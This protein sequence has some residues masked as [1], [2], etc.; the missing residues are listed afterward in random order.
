M[1]RFKLPDG[2]VDSLP[3][4]AVEMLR[5]VCP[6][7]VGHA[8]VATYFG[9]RVRGIALTQTT[10]GLQAVAIYETRI[11]MPLE[12]RWIIK[13]AGPAGEVVAF[14]RYGVLGASIDRQHVRA[15]GYLDDFELLVQKATSILQTRR[16]RFDRLVSLLKQKIES[17]E[18][19]T[20]E[21]LRRDKLGVYLLDEAALAPE[22][23]IS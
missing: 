3:P 15:I 23:P 17:N 14:G 11:A 18:V 7:E 5:L 13:A 22:K 10:G 16:I 1:V 12:D 6:H 21:P 19:L 4:E 20:M 2:S 8:E 9:A